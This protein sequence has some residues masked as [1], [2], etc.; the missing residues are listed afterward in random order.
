MNYVIMKGAI[1]QLVRHDINGM[2]S[3][4]E[5]LA[6]LHEYD[7]REQLKST[8]LSLDDLLK[9]IVFMRD[10]I[11]EYVETNEHNVSPVY[12]TKKY[13]DNHIAEEIS[14]NEIAKKVH[15]NPDY[16]TRIFKQEVGVSIARYII[17]RKMD[18][19]KQLLLET[20]KTISEVAWEVGYFNYSSF[21]KTFIKLVGMSPQAFKTV[22]DQVWHKC[23]ESIIAYVGK[24]LVMGCR[25]R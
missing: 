4:I 3:E 22:S 20:D 18:R 15:P 14:M 10:I 19:A 5:Y 2:I 21:Y 6:D 9:H 17:I 23:R 25:Q 11:E 1:E 8:L 24:T 16:L 12:K 7:Q 13:I